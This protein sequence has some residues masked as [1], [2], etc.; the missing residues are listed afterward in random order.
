MTKLK[1][2]KNADYTLT[3][4]IEMFSNEN[5]LSS[6]GRKNYDPNKLSKKPGQ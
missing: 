6:E 2:I 3:I 1:K 4:L 5:S